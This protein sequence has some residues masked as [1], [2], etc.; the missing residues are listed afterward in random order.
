MGKRRNFSVEFK[1]NAIDKWRLFDRN[2]KK[3]ESYF[4]IDRKTFEIVLRGEEGAEL[5]VMMT[6]SWI[7][8]PL[9]VRVKLRKLNKVLINSTF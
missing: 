1:I 2:Y 4:E 5:S 8:V 3:T 6:L 9:V 7:I